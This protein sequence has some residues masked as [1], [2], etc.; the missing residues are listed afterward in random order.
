M[1]LD[2]NSRDFHLVAF[3]VV[4][5]PE[6]SDSQLPGCQFVGPQWLPFSARPVRVGQ[7]VAPDGA[8]DDPLLEG[9]EMLQVAVGAVTAFAGFGSWDRLFGTLEADMSG[10]S[11]PGEILAEA[12]L[13]QRLICRIEH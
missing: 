5:D 1:R 7:Q 10:V 8:D 2:A 11:L 9:S 4:E 12:L 6:G 13:P 3:D